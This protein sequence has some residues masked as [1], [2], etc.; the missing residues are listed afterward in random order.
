MDAKARRSV[1]G[2]VLVTMPHHTWCIIEFCVKE[3]FSMLSHDSSS[4]DSTNQH[5][6]DTYTEPILMRSHIPNG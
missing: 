2:R 3:F 5:G 6:T 4:F 1:H